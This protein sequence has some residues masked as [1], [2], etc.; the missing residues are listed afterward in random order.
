MSPAKKSNKSEVETK[1]ITI[2]LTQ[3]SV[4]NDK[5]LKDVAQFLQ[6]KITDLET[7][8]DGNSLV[9]TVD[10]DFSRRKIKNYL[11]KFLYLADLDKKF[12]PIALQEE[13]KGYQI[14]KRIDIE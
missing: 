10:Q 8:R 7:V 13:E 11:K 6:E 2:D 5:Y 1:N 4:E 12:R 9:I 3:L 14:H